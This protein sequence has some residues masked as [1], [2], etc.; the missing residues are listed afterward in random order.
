MKSKDRSES[1]KRPQ[2]RVPVRCAKC[3]PYN[4]ELLGKDGPKASRAQIRPAPVPKLG[5]NTVLLDQ[6]IAAGPGGIRKAQRLAL[7]FAKKYQEE[8][9][10]H[11]RKVT[12]FPP[13]LD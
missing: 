8:T 5:F 7:K 6:A 11:F 13:T 1:A 9:I 2:K 12:A 3:F 10:D 4:A